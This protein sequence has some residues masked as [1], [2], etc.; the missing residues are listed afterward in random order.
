MK[1]NSLKVQITLP[2]ELVDKIEEE[3][4][5]TY[6]SKSSWFLERVMDYF[7]GKSSNKFIELD[8]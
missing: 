6:Q 7:K 5:G 3:L 2:S 4:D 8:I 1:K